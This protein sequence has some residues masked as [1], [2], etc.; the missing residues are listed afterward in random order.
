V[1]ELV[2][3]S[4]DSQIIGGQKSKQQNLL[5]EMSDELV[6]AGGLYQLLA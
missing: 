3:I 2:S 4:H 5:I 1:F 6:V